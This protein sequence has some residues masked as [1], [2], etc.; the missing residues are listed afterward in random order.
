VYDLFG[1]REVDKS[2]NEI[3]AIKAR[4]DDKKLAKVEGFEAIAKL[5]PDVKFLRSRVRQDTNVLAHL[6]GGSD[7]NS[8]LE[9]VLGAGASFLNQ[10]LFFLLYRSGAISLSF[11]AL[12]DVVNEF[13]VP[14]ANVICRHGADTMKH[15]ESLF[16]DPKA[17]EMRLAL[18]KTEQNQTTGRHWAAGYFPLH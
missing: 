12:E 5:I 8:S 11:D 14:P 16:S 1:K 18:F 15:L 17:V 9:N 4:I 13:D 7:K 3:R 2:E 10:F 6:S